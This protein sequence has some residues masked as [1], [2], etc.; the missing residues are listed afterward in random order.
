MG[1]LADP[2]HSWR[3]GFKAT[4]ERLVVAVAPDDFDASCLNLGQ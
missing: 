3:M 2:D 4:L 1:L